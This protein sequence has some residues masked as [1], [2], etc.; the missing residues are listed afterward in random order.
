MEK[1]LERYNLPGLKQEEIDNMNRSITLTEIETVTKISFSK[2][3]PDTD[4]FTGEFYQIFKEER[5]RSETILKTYRRNM[6]K[7]TL[8][9]NHH[10]DTNIRQRYHRRI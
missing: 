10:P 3:N 8:Q 9:G 5:T 4:G 6:P 1:F 7:F 2:Q